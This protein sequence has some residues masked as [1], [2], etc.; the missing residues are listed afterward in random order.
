MTP[1]TNFCDVVPAGTMSMKV[2]MIAILANPKITSR[3]MVT[4][5]T[6]HRKRQANCIS[7][8]V[9]KTHTVTANTTPVTNTEATSC[10]TRT[11]KM[12]TSNTVVTEG[13]TPMKV[14]MIAT[15]ANLMI[16]P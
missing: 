6:L 3:V 15:L 2:T 12:W 4:E 10:A 9:I 8:T 14:M 7:S 16:T 11:A 5:G 1:K 13:A